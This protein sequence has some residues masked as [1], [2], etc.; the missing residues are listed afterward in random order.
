M[1]SKS[2]KSEIRN[3][4]LGNTIRQREGKRKKEQQQ[5]KE[6][7]EKKRYQKKE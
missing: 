4:K 3:I 7:Q 5:K 1:R 6:R 2:R